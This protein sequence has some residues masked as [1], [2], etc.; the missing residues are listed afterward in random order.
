MRRTGEG[1]GGAV[2]AVDDALG[3]AFEGGWRDGATMGR[4]YGEVKEGG[5]QEREDHVG[6][7]NG[8]RGEPGGDS[9]GEEGMEPMGTADD[10]AAVEFGEFGDEVGER[11]VVGGGGKEVERV[12]DVFD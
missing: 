10:V 11:L 1:E 9:V 3:A 7:G 12:V 4:S 8:R 6:V 5:G 2:A